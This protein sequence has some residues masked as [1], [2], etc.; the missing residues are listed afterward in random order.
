MMPGRFVSSFFVLIVLCKNKFKKMFLLV[1]FNAFTLQNVLNVFIHRKK[2][3]QGLVP[4]SIPT[5]HKWIFYRNLLGEYSGFRLV[6]A[7][8]LPKRFVCISA[9]LSRPEDSDFRG[10]VQRTAQPAPTHYCCRY[11]NRVKFNL[12]TFT[13]LKGN[14][15]MNLYIL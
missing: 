12:H 13:R 6:L 10:T 9:D 8:V 5:K 3:K 1:L 15:C 14:V 2:K 4:F 7:A 11:C